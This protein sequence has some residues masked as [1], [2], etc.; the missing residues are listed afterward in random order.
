M[1]IRRIARTR[2]KDRRRRLEKGDLNGET[3]E[4]KRLKCEMEKG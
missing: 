2:K 1:V 3:G 4:G